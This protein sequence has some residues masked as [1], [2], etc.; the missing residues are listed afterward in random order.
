MSHG[1]VRPWTRIEKATTTKAV[2]MMALRSGTVGGTAK[3]NANA[4]AP[5]RPPQ[6]SVCW[7]ESFNFHRERMNS[8]DNG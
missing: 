5:R 2:K 4:S 3:A 6:K 7:N 8:S 1:M